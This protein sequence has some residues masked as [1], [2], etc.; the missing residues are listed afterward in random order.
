[1]SAAATR[2]R[3]RAKEFDP[4]AYEKFREGHKR[5][6]FT[7]AFNASLEAKIQ[8]STLCLEMRF[9]LLLM[10]QAWG[11]Q[12]DFAVHD[13]D[14]KKPFTQADC[15]RVLDV[16]RQTISRLVEKWVQASYLQ[17]DGKQLRPVDNP[18]FV[19]YVRD[20]TATEPPDFE[21]L[22]R[23][24]LFEESPKA[25]RQYQMAMKRLNRINVEI[26]RRAR[27]LSRTYVTN[28]ASGTATNS[29]NF[30]E[31]RTGHENGN[32]PDYGENT[33]R[34]DFEASY[35]RSETVLNGES[36]SSASSAFV[37]STTTS[38]PFSQEELLPKPNPPENQQDHEI[39]A[40]AVRRHGKTDPEAIRKLIALSRQA[41]PR[42][43]A[44]EIA[45]AVDEKAP[46]AKE[47]LNG[48]LWA[49]VPKLFA[50]G[51]LD[52]LRSAPPPA[53]TG[54]NLTLEEQYYHLRDLLESLPSGHEQRPALEQQRDEVRK[55]LYAQ[56]ARS[57]R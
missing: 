33:G 45:D 18:G 20:K 22:A 10:L 9:D 36:A 16:S 11:N 51:A 27:I 56:G 19:T 39:V 5:E 1:M 4:V 26:R 47:S 30:E 57:G 37:D 8:N 53:A 3:R 49:A 28:E 31:G 17:V 46:Q 50:A 40:E 52:K 2:V 29:G 25:F 14:R 23:E 7:P 35:I 42:V 15:A 41:D 55:R 43:T 48:F 12:S 6:D 34:T 21:R 44:Q 24:Q 38:P 13:H 32:V 54:P